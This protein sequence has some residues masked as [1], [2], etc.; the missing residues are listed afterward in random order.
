MSLIVP[1][2]PLLYP[3]TADKKGNKM[4]HYGTHQV[5][6]IPPKYIKDVIDYLLFRYSHILGTLWPI[7]IRFTLLLLY[8]TYGTIR[9]IWGYFYIL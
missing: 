6:P 4:R 9:D 8:G 3:I 7:C 1:L 5:Y 2:T